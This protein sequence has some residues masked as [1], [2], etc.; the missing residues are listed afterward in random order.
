VNYIAF[1]VIGASPALKT[2]TPFAL[3]EN[4]TSNNNNNNNTIKGNRK[5]DKTLAAIKRVNCASNTK[6]RQQLTE[7]LFN[8]FQTR[9]IAAIDT[10]C[11]KI[12][13]T[14]TTTLFGCCLFFKA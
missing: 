3:K 1:R 11:Q 14:R 13:S 5:E 9:T 6:L 4:L 8:G 7:L 2:T 12:L 10:P